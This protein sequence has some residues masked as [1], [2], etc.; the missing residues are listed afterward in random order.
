MDSSGTA[1][2][3][4][5]YY[6]QYFRN[7]LCLISLCAWDDSSAAG[8]WAARWSYARASSGNDVGFRA[9]CYPD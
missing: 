8:P 6:Y 2:F 3:G 9:A 5:D 4:Q 1:M 7:E